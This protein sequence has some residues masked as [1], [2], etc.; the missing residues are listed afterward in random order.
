MQEM[1]SEVGQKVTEKAPGND[2]VLTR[3]ELFYNERLT[4]E[5]HYMMLHKGFEIFET[6]TLHIQNLNDKVALRP[7]TEDWLNF[8][9]VIEHWDRTIRG[10]AVK[11]MD[12]KD[13]QEFEEA[14]LNTTV[15][16][17]QILGAIEGYP[18]MFHMGIVA[19][20]N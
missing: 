5:Q 16:D 12:P 17:Q 19:F 15:L 7:S 9:Q 10:V 4:P 14:V 18:K 11:D 8:R 6:E 2:R 1:A 3:A 20:T 13:F